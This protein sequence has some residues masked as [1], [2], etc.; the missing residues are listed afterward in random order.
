MVCLGA[1]FAVAGFAF[2]GGAGAGD[3]SFALAGIR[4]RPD[5]DSSSPSSG[6]CGS[7]CH[8]AGACR[9]RPSPADRAYRRLAMKPWQI[10]GEGG[11]T[12]MSA[13][14]LPV[15]FSHELARQCTPDRAKTA[16]MQDAPSIVNHLGIAAHHDAR[17]FCGNA[18]AHFFFQ[19]AILQKRGNPLVEALIRILHFTGG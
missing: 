7:A 16:L 14:G 15:I 13:G 3:I 19:F 6:A 10:A 1:A 8:T 5:L 11:R 4:T 17:R 9:L 12:L 18:Q 2:P